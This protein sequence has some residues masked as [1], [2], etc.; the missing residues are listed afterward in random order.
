[1]T[2]AIDLAEVERRF[3]RHVWFPVARS[4]D[5]TD[6]VL[7]GR[8]LGVDL[9]VYRHE[10]TAVVA[11]GRCPHRGVAMW[12]GRT[13]AHG[14]EC[15]YHGWVF[16]PKTGE[17]VAVPSLPEG[18]AIGHIQ[19]ATYPVTEAYGHVWTSL[20]E[21]YL[22]L[23]ELT[24]EPDAG[25][26]F[27]HGVPHDLRCGM[28]QLTENFRDIAHFPFVHSGSMG[29]NVRRVVDPY[30]VTRQGW[31]LEWEMTTDLGGTA[32][33]GAA[34]LANRIRLI[35][36]VALPMAATVRT[37]FPDGGRRFLA[38]FATP[39]DEDGERVRLFW[40]LG[41]DRIV[42]EVHGV[43]MDR[44]WEYEQQIF[45]EDYPI[46]ENQLPVEAPLDLHTQQHTAADRYSI[47]YRKAYVELLHR[48]HADAGAP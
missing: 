35:H 20:A 22:P 32:L 4:E 24:I 13:V 10:G 28:R 36:G 42:R 6:T 47:V 29:P 2:A 34:A 8:L 39:L 45:E 31:S 1:M 7:P 37:R 18:G 5:L 23:P 14:I 46:V 48:F 27:S 15:P 38:Q 12:L 3:L 19:L 17:C 40:T 41:I 43:D 44:M 30:R 9:V 25:W 16:A 33:D 21:P 11:A 26:A